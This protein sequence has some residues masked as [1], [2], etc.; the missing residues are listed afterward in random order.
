MADEA[1]YEAHELSKSYGEAGNRV[2]ALRGVDFIIRRG[3]LTAITGPSGSGK[4]TLL[5]L[6]G[7]LTRPSSGKLCF[8]GQDVT[9][10]DHARLATIR[11][12]EIG[13]VFQN[14]QL[15]ERASAVENVELPLVY[16]GVKPRLRRERALQALHR[17]GLA[18]RAG[19]VPNQ[20]SG[21]EQQ[22]VAIARAIINDPSVILADEPTGALDTQT[23]DDILHLLR[24]LNLRGTSV[25]IITHNLEVADTIAHHIPLVDGALASPVQSAQSG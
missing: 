15:L 19:H 21:G 24:E 17:V 9:H 13:F 5:G 1:L 11:N 7:M 22:R 18:D 23:G 3:E 20:L 12:S 16:A 8:H 4:S 14:F 2:E 10:L 25:V 6:L